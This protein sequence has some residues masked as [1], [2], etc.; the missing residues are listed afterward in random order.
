M[1]SEPLVSILTPVYN[2]EN[3][4][5]EC[6]ESIIKQNY[7]NLEY[8]IVNNC[9][10]DSTLDIASRYANIDSRIHVVNNQKF[11]GII[12]NHNIAFKLISPKS[13]YCK[14][15]SADDW[16]T[17]DYLNEMVGFAENHP[18]VGIVGC[19][20]ISGESIKWKMPKDVE[21][22][23][24][25]ELCRFDLLK[26]G[27]NFGTPTSLLYRSDMVRKCERFYPHSLSYADTSACYEQLQHIDFGFV[28]KILS[29]E[30]IHDQQISESVRNMGKGEVAAI[31]ILLEFGPIYLNDNELKMRKKEIIGDY[32][33]WLGGC[34]LKMKNKEFWAYHSSNLKALGYPISWAEVIKCAIMKIF[35]DSK[36]P[37]LAITKLRNV[38]KKYPRKSD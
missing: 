1:K 28:K 31:Q 36:N 35:E 16:I 32:H 34:V 4:I 18:T 23:S 38:L 27:E 17:P 8:I 33:K 30:R 14:V 25:R 13:V 29:F 3:Y 37:K 24:G 6:I 11:V 19:Y 22:I 10:N 5:A 20:Q 9:S 26:G 12:E 15:V 21:V 2:G 7:H